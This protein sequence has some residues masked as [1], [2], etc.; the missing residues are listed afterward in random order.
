MKHLK[1]FNENRIELSE[2]NNIE[3]YVK[4]SFYDFCIDYGLTSRFEYGIYTTSHSFIEEEI[5]NEMIKTHGDVEISKSLG[6]THKCCKVILLNE[7]HFKGDHN[8]FE[9]YTDENS[10]KEFDYAFI[11]LNK[12][13]LEILD[14]FK[15]I[16]QDYKISPKWWQIIFYIQY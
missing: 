7:S 4:E 2:K 6:K 16:C 9:I 1:K 14:D 12:T 10:Q 15:I 5:Y 8:R 3:N 13:L 11:N